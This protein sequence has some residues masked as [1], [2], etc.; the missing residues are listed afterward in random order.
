MAASW[1]SVSTSQLHARRVHEDERLAE[2]LA[3]GL[4][5]ARGLA[6]AGFEIE[7]SVQHVAILRRVRVILAQIVEHLRQTLVH[8]REDA[9]GVR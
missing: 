2:A 1:R 8:G 5:S 7:R 6:L 9:P 4:I 3:V